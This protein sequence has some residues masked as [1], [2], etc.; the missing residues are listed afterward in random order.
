MEATAVGGPPTIAP[1]AQHEITSCTQGPWALPQWVEKSSIAEIANDA[2]VIVTGV[3]TDRWID[4]DS[5]RGRELP[6][7][8]HEFDVQ[9]VIKGPADL[10]SQIEFARS[11][12]CLE[13]DE[14]HILMLRDAGDRLQT[15]DDPELSE[16]PAQYIYLGPFATFRFM[17]GLLVPDKQGTTNLHKPRLGASVAEIEEEIVASLSPD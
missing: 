16:S 15:T 3:I 2:D 9:R 1:T 10:P 12:A 11:D 8:V 7:G 13:V 5:L 6:I 4:Y 14:Q 17:D